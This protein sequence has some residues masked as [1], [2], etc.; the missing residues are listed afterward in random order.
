MDDDDIG[1]GGLPMFFFQCCERSTSTHGIGRSL[2]MKALM[3]TLKG[4]KKDQAGTRMF[5]DALNTPWLDI[6]INGV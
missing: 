4:K 6:V 1:T 2:L 5:L 3:C